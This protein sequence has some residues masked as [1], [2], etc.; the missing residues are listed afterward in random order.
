MNQLLHNILGFFPRR[1]NHYIWKNN[2]AIRLEKFRNIHKDEDCFIIGNGPSLN[3]MDLGLLNDYYT[4]GLNKIYLLFDRTGLKID[5]HTCINRFV[6]E[7][8]ALQFKEMNCHSFLSYKY[9]DRRL[10]NMEK[11]YLLGD[12]RSKNK[13]F[14]DIT[15]GISQ[16][17]TVTYVAMQIAFFMGF[18]NVYLIGVDHSFKDKGNPHKVQV[19]KEDDQNHFDPG[20]FKG[21]KWQLPDLA[22]SEVSYLRAKEAFD[23]NGRN[24]F[25]ATVNG[26]LTVFPKIKFEEALVAAKRKEL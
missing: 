26:K 15:E 8:S 23:K 5:Y 21:H 9:R 13:F 12:A 11:V 18:K 4:F 17:N 2:E 19:M 6:I 16:G 3:Q 1:I 7:Q 20:Y 22:G 10:K 25:D 24:I 14:T